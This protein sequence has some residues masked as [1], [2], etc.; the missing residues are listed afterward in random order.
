MRLV[1]RQQD[2]S[3]EAD[4]GADARLPGVSDLD[5][6]RRDILNYSALLGWV[7][8]A[9]AERDAQTRYHRPGLRRSN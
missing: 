9:V 1:I 8:S 2:L 7:C 3:K 5:M 4:L 6:Q